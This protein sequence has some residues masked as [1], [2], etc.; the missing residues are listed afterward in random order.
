MLV[1]WAQAAMY[2]VLTDAANK[3]FFKMN[4]IEKVSFISE[5]SSANSV[6]S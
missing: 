4:I 2:R 5:V 6:F 1:H 3:I